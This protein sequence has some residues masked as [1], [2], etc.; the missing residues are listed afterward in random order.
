MQV[1]AYKNRNEQIVA[2]NLALQNEFVAAEQFRFTTTLENMEREKELLIQKGVDSE[3]IEQAHRDRV[4]LLEFDHQ[5]KMEQA[6][7]K[8][9]RGVKGLANFEIASA[10]DK[11][12]ILLN[13]ALTLTQG[14]EGQSKTMFKINKLASIASTIVSTYEGA[15][16]VFT[17][18]AKVNPLAAAA[19]AAVAVAAGLARV[20]AISKTRFGGG[21][22]SAGGG[23]GGSTGSLPSATFATSDLFTGPQGTT[24]DQEGKG[25]LNIYI[26]QLHSNDP[27]KWVDDLE[28]L[29]DRD[30]IVINE[31]TAQAQV[32]AKELI[33]MRSA[34]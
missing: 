29:F 23:V 8:Q 17:A 11:T 16:N 13:Q 7:R 30:I 27:E 33:R 14:L 10:K 31:G 5:H 3:E 21:A 18:I 28:G 9:Q 26:D 2:A 19:A 12:K 6:R 20:A 34:A 24:A 15:Q 25:Q 1:D 32:I 22:S 4:L